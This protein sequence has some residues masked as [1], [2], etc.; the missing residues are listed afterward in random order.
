MMLLLFALVVLLLGLALLYLVFTYNRFKTLKN[1][2]E[3]TFYQI[4]V[5]LKKRLDTLNALLENLQSSARFERNL[6]REIV[7]LR[8]S[9][10]NAKNEKELSE[11]EGKLLSLLPSVKA[12]AEAYPE[13][14]TLEIAKEVSKAVKEL[15]DEIARQ[16]YL[17]N[18]IVQEYN[19]LLETFPSNL[20]GRLFSFER[21]E[22]LEIPKEVEKRPSLRWE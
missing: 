18:N 4:R 21:F 12:L 9:I 17:F 3:A 1:A 15:E 5:A 10:W 8:N 13:I 2:K 11:A 19:T 20:V 7:E 6:L 16:R 14:K 22:Y